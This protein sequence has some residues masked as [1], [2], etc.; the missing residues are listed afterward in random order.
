MPPI[1]IWPLRPIAAIDK[2]ICRPA[3]TPGDSPLP[4]AGAR[5]AAVASDALDPGAPP[6][7]ATRVGEIRKALESGAY[8]IDPARVVDAM[9]AAGF[10]RNGK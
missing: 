10:L 6:V 1:E 4:T 5:P 9:F 2:R 7:D 3:D 8:Q